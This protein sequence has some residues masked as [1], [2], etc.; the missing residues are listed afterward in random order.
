MVRLGERGGHNVG[1]AATEQ[2]TKEPLGGFVGIAGE[3]QTVIATGI[4]GPQNDRIPIHEILSLQSNV[5]GAF[6]SA[7]L[8]ARA[9]P[10]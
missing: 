8:R 10:F 3:N 9:G 1:G 4:G 5:V 6:V 2:K 7:T